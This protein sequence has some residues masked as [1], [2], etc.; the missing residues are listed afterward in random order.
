MPA[1]TLR[2]TLNQCAFRVVVIVFIRELDPF[3]SQTHRMHA[4]MAKNTIKAVGFA[5]ISCQK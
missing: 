4:Y 2:A 5:N 1:I 3:F